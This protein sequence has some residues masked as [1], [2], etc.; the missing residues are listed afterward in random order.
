MRVTIH[1]KIQNG[2]FDTVAK[3]SVM[4]M[5]QFNG[6]CG[7]PVVVSQNTINIYL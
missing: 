6:I 2:I 3:A 7:C 4:G 5:K 1:A